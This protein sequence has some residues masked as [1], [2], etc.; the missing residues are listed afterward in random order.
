VIG[1]TL[2]LF[3]KLGNLLVL[4]NEGIVFF[5]LSVQTLMPLYMLKQGLWSDLPELARPAARLLL[6]ACNLVHVVHLCHLLGLWSDLPELA[7]PAARLLLFACNLVHVVHLCHLLAI[8]HVSKDRRKQCMLY[9]KNLNYTMQQFRD[10]LP[11]VCFTLHLYIR[12]N[13]H[14]HQDQTCHITSCCCA[15][16]GL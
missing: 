4:C 9:I 10:S 13:L 5:N 15:P 11:H 1:E 12:T 6:F 2:C 16:S 7:R 8:R 14:E 3:N